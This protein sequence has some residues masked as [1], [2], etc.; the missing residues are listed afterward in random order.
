[1]DELDQQ[2]QALALEAQG[3]PPKT[4]QR[5]RALSK[6]LSAIQRSG[7]LGYPQRGKFKGFYAEVRALA[8]QGLFIYVCEHIHLYNP[9]RATVLAWVNYLLSRRF[10]HEA[11]REFMHTR[12]K[13]IDANFQCLSLDDLEG[14]IPDIDPDAKQF[15]DYDQLRQLLQTDPDHCFQATHVRHHPQATFQAIALGRLDEKSW[16]ALSKDLKVKVPTLS[17]FYQTS[18]HRFKPV[19]EKYLNP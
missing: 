2:L 15:S 9:S 1:M 18:L 12:P 14:N 19:F 8:L 11:S 5:R 7:R 13:G 10:F 3:A 16:D 6:L 4:E 17:S